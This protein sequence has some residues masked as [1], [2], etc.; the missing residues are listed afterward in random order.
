MTDE[1]ESLRRMVEHQIEA[2]GITDAAVLR[3][4]REVPRA[5]FVT[6]DLAR[7]AYDDGP[8]PIGSEQTISQPYIV[9]L[10]LE[11]AHLGPSSVVLEI[12]AGS[13]YVAAI[14]SRIVRRVIAIERLDDLAHAARDR[15]RQLDCPNVDIRSGDG[16]NGAPE[17]APFDAIIVSAAG[18]FL[19]SVLRSQL[20]VDGRLVMPIGSISGQRLIC[21]TRQSRGQFDEEDLGPVR[22][23]PL[24]GTHG[25][26][27]PVSH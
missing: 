7:F 20:A 24:I 22:F 26:P 4:I 6:P 2:R 18:P 13:G 12:G 10:M 27:S 17:D 1:A 3:A 8:L 25:W 23:V 19:P 14:V 9:A 11:A 5:F 15:L 16:S 21:T